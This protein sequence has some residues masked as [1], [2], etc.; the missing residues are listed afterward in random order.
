M[1]KTLTI[2]LVLAT[3]LALGGFAGCAPKETE[4][5]EAT[6]TQVSTATPTTAPSPDETVPTPDT[7]PTAGAAPTTTP[8]AAAISVP[9]ATGTKRPG[10]VAGSTQKPVVVV[11]PTQRPASATVWKELPL[12]EP[13]Y[14]NPSSIEFCPRGTIT[15]TDYVFSGKV[16][17][18]K[19]YEATW[20]IFEDDQEYPQRH[21][22]LILEVKII[23][24]I[25]GKRPAAVE[26]NI[27]RVNRSA[28]SSNYGS[29]DVLIIQDKEYVFVTAAYDEEFLALQAERYPNDKSGVENFAD[30]SV[31]LGT[32]TLFPMEDGN[33]VV[34]HDYFEH[35]M[36]NIKQ[37]VILIDKLPANRVTEDCLE[38]GFFIGLSM[39]DFEREF[40]E[41]FKDP[42]KMPTENA[43][44]CDN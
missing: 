20:T 40:P 43:C 24:D 26:G 37:C 5:P 32:T 18:I 17:G 28:S 6:A 27:I 30:V 22:F 33:V 31:G 35:I 11:E 14:P 19:E 7:T 10:V 12:Q 25:Y 42:S 36:D 23:K 15:N 1:K 41:L 8:S 21:V 16:I 39:E 9:T 29:H 44:T 13:R 2:L 34:F 4:K 38:L 3:L